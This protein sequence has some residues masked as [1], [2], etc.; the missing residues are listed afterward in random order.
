[1]ATET[2]EHRGV[3]RLST[4]DRR[5]RRPSAPSRSPRCPHRP[6]YARNGNSSRHTLQGTGGGCEWRVLVA[7]QAATHSNPQP[8]IQTVRERAIRTE[9]SQACPTPRKRNGRAQSFGTCSPSQMRK[10]NGHHEA[11]AQQAKLPRAHPGFPETSQG[12]PPIPLVKTFRLS[13]H[14][15]A[16]VYLLSNNR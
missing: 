7:A 2:G 11:G 5:T 16:S 10:P 8:C 12:S 13:Q 4:S 1:M 14:C 9:R 3:S 15:P 6:S